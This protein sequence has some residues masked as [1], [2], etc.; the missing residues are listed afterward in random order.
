ME[1]S[2]VGMVRQSCAGALDSYCVRNDITAE[3]MPM[4]WKGCC[5]GQFS[6]TPQIHLSIFTDTGDSGAGFVDNG[7]DRGTARL[8]GFEHH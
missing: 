8:A 7:T 5:Y 6:L 4:L 2:I 1:G 3:G